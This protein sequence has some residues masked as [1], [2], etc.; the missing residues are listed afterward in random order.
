MIQEPK[1]I[2]IN[3]LNIIG[4]KDN[5]DIFAEEMVS[6]ILKT[7][8]FK[9]INDIPEKSK[10]TLMLRLKGINSLESA[11]EILKNYVSISDFHNNLSSV[12]S[13]MMQNYLENIIPTLN[14]S[15]KNSLNEYL[16][17]I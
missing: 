3:I 15:Q 14:P 7:A 2:I 4:Y 1:Q 11:S 10:T 17:N 6:L 8:V 5:K 16:K 13:L 9:S 12:T